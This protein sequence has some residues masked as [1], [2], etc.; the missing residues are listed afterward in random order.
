[1]IG[2]P[3]FPGVARRVACR[4]R[5]VRVHGCPGHYVLDG[6]H[7]SAVARALGE[8]SVWANITEVRLNDPAAIAVGNAE[9]TPGQ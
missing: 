3:A 5:G 4:S 7:R 6:H 9:V 8:R 1:M 2:K